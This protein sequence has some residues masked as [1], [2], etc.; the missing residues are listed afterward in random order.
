MI[1]AELIEELKRLPQHHPIVVDVGLR[2]NESIQS[3]MT[4]CSA[5]SRLGPSVV[6]YTDSDPRNVAEHER[7][8]EEIDE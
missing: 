8:Y 6:I 3:V 5:D 4:N 7:R 2:Y 1:V